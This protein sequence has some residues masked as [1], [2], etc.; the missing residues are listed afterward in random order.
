MA[1]PWRVQL[2]G[3]IPHLLSV[4]HMLVAPVPLNPRC[5]GPLQSSSYD[6]ISGLEWDQARNMWGR[7]NPAA[8]TTVPG[9]PGMEEDPRILLPRYSEDLQRERSYKMLSSATACRLADL[10]AVGRSLLSVSFGF[11]LLAWGL[12]L[13]EAAA[14]G[15]KLGWRWN[16]Y[17]G[18][19]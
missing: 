9:G 5:L 14:L 18:I 10:V 17:W 13:Q 11:H 19:A 8:Y 4:S 15:A 3:H 1:N 6:C 12:Q 16:G 2:H 7:W